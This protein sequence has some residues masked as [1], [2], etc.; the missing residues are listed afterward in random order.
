M[1]KGIALILALMLMIGLVAC[2]SA[3]EKQSN[4]SGEI[5]D[6]MGKKVTIEKK[7][8]RIVSLTP[9]GTEILFA[10]GVGDKLVGVDAYSDYPEE[11]KNLE[12]VGDFNGPNV[13]KILGL[14]PDLVIAG[15]KL[16]EKAI[17]QLEQL[18]VTTVAVE[19][20]TY[21]E[22]YS[23]IELVGKIIG[24]PEKA[25]ELLNSMKEKEETV[26]DKVKDA[27]K[28]TVYYV[29][30][31]GEAGNWTSGPGSFINDII[32]LAGGDC[33]TKDGGAA[34]MNYNLE[35]LIERDPDILL[36]SS[37]IGDL[38]SLKKENGYKDLKAVKE[39][40]VYQVDSGLITRP[41][42]RINDGLEMVAR[43]LHPDLF[44]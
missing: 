27:P 22:I 32:E 38:E 30:S 40:R 8:E 21:G 17:E 11:A 24:E 37:D 42:P 5:I 43:I 34:W 16:Q 3:N 44:K 13:E 35:D 7:P 33:I 39:G 6:I 26:T 28:P 14:K 23:S 18:Q 41:G 31:Y 2:Q 25:T 36:V 9:A 20:S 15:N 19:S 1:K 29:M 12:K 10:L 4:A